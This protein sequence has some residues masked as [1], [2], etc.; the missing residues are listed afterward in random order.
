MKWILLS[1]FVCFINRS[2]AVV[3]LSNVSVSSAEKKYPKLFVKTQEGFQWSHA[4]LNISG[5]FTVDKN[6]LVANCTLLLAPEAKI[7]IAAGNTFTLRSDGE[8]QTLLKAGDK[9]MWDGIYIQGSAAHLVSSSASKGQQTTIQDARNAIVSQNGGDFL[10]ERTILQKNNKDIVVTIYPT[11]NH[12]GR[13]RESILQTGTGT[14]LPFFTGNI[15]NAP[16]PRTNM[17]IQLTRVKDIQ[18]GDASAGV[19][20]NLF[21]NMD[22][23]ISS[24][25]SKL[26]IYN[27]NFQN[28]TSFGNGKA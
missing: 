16:L 23:G 1:M 13:V 15:L 8:G 7:M 18:I 24:I 17:G 9:I 4:S 25:G 26:K 20:A 12:T 27:N 5:T 19:G 22:V 28:I 2:F 14:L 10:V 21:D 3:T 11:V 6:L